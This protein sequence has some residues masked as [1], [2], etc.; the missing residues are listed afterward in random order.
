MYHETRHSVYLKML[1][2]C[3]IGC[4]RECGRGEKREY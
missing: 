4:V 3:M 2:M 1:K